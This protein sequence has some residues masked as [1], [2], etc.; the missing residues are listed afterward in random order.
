MPSDIKALYN[1]YDKMRGG[2]EKKRTEAYQKFAEAERNY[3]Y[4]HFNMTDTFVNVCENA[5]VCPYAFTHRCVEG[6]SYENAGE[7]YFIETPDAIYFETER[8]F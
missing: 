8:H 7:I 6:S 3:L 1:V 4:E 5:V 2:N